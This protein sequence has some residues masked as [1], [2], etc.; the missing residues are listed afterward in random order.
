MDTEA[1]FGK[2]YQDNIPDLDA[3][4]EDDSP[5]LQPEEEVRPSTYTNQGLNLSIEL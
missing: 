1:R 4:P 5:P 3:H 2:N